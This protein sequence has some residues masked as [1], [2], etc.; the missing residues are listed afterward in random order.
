MAHF[1]VNHPARPLYR[2]LRRSSASTSW[3]S[4]SGASF[5]TWGD[6]LFGRGDALAL[7]LRTNLAFSLVSV[8]FGLS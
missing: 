6:R 7:G 2:A 1:P 4:A 3:S 5:E 8:I